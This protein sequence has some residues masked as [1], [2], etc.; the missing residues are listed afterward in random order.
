MKARRLSL[1]SAS[2]VAVLVL[3][4]VGAARG[5]QC[6]TT[7]IITRHVDAFYG[8]VTVSNGSS[9][10]A[11]ELTDHVGLELANGINADRLVDVRVRGPLLS[12]TGPIYTW[13]NSQ[14]NIEWIFSPSEGL[15]AQGNLQADFQAFF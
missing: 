15:D 7:R 12:S 8:T 9:L 10:D 11:L 13:T 14:T 6:D 2:I 3:F 4:L 5:Q 1:L